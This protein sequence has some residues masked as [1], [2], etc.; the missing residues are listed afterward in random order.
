MIWIF[1]FIVISICLS[2]LITGIKTISGI[3]DVESAIKSK[4]NKM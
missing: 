3:N 2:N 4:I 1:A